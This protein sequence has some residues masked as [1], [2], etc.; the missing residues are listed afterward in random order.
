[1]HLCSLY[2][3][4]TAPYGLI[5]CADNLMR[6]E[7]CVGGEDPDRSPD[8]QGNQLQ[9]RSVAERQDGGQLQHSRGHLPVR[10]SVCMIAPHSAQLL[11]LRHH[12]LR[13]GSP[14]REHSA[15]VGDAAQR[16]GLPPEQQLDGM[17]SLAPCA[18]LTGPTGPRPHVRRLDRVPAGQQHGALHERCN[19][20]SDS[21]SHRVCGVTFS[22]PP[23]AASLC[24]TPQ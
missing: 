10:T 13:A 11:R 20:G 5:R 23:L 12:L 1:M 6:T 15:V 14:R 21:R 9:G 3:G 19:P 8:A 2:L 7:L 4:I 18:S 16:R 24:A 22:S 17:H